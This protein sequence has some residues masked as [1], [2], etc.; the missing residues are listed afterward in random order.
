MVK[1]LQDMDV[2]LIKK[3]I[4]LEL[5]PY[6]INSI[7]WNNLNSK[8]YPEYKNYHHGYALKQIRIRIYSILKLEILLYLR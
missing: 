3:I 2:A 1:I 6:P 5:N 8:Q 4:L 7:Q